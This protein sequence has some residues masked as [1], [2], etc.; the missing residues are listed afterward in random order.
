MAK[1]RIICR[2]NE[3]PPK[4]WEQMSRADQIKWWKDRQGPPAPKLHMKKAINLFQRGIITQS[5]FVIT[6][7][8]TA[9]PEEI[10]EVVRVCPPEL[11]TILKEEL[12]RY[13]KDEK[14]WPRS[15]QMVSYWPWVTAE[16]IKE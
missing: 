9:A 7:M 3:I 2:P 11:M 10:E 13:G 5:G 4:E 6:T 15:F 16:E 8:R 12:A 1:E 14:K